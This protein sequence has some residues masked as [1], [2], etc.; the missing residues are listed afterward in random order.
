MHAAHVT[1]SRTT[2]IRLRMFDLPEDGV[3]YNDL[4]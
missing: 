2:V 4:D 3:V 1:L